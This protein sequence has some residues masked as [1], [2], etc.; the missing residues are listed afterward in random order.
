MIKRLHSICILKKEKQAILFEGSNSNQCTYCLC[1]KY[2]MFMW[3]K[4]LT[5]STKS[6]AISTR[7][8]STS[9]SNFSDG[10]ICNKLLPNYEDC[11]AHNFQ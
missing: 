10:S 7:T 9:E 11:T 4:E 8:S 5:D 3:A 2:T 6:S 1:S